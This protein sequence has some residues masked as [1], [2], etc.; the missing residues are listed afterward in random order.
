MNPSFIAI[1]AAAAVA[2]VALVAW[3]L[4]RTAGAATALHGRRDWG[5]AVLVAVLL[6]GGAAGLYVTWSNWSWSQPTRLRPAARPR[7]WSRPRAT[8]GDAAGGPAGLAR[9]AARTRRSSS[10]RSRRAPTSAPAISPAIAMPM[11]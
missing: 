7:T 4:L 11:R 3:P 8:P 10:I 2:A 6:C 1:A 5:A 9:S